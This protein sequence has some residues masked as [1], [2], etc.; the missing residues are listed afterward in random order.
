MKIETG[1]FI[2]FDN[3]LEDDAIF[4]WTQVLNTLTFF[5]FSAMYDFQRGAINITIQDME[6]K[7]FGAFVSVEFF[8]YLSPNQI[9]QFLERVLAGK[10]GSVM[11]DE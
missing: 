8:T 3:W 1:N 5:R 7:A 10:Y 4:K 11:G 6:R 9:R 2:S